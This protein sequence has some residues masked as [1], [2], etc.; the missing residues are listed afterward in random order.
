MNLGSI[1]LRRWFGNLLRESFQRFYQRRRKNDEKIKPSNRQ[2]NEIVCEPKFPR[3]GVQ[4]NES[5][6]RAKA[7]CVILSNFQT[8]E[9]ENALKLNLM[10]FFWLIFFFFSL[11]LLAHIDFHSENI[12][13]ASS[14]RLQ[15]FTS[16]A[17]SF[18]SH[19][20]CTFIFIKMSY[21][22]R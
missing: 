4:R 1:C 2:K 8:H 7:K 11:L 13:I 19:F 17:F 21:I 16:F 18:F 14:I 3:N 10:D 20:L 15:R 5:Q 22:F 6:S 12:N 9:I